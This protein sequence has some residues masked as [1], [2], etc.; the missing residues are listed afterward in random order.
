M[1]VGSFL[2][3]DILNAHFPIFIILCL[4]HLKVVKTNFIFNNVIIPS[5]LIVPCLKAGHVLD[6]ELYLLSRILYALKLPVY[7]SQHGFDGCGNS[8]T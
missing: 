2:L 1:E 7:C 4:G 5:A 8:T 3:G 6:Y